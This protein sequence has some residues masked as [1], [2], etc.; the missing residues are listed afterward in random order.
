MTAFATTVAFLISLTTAKALDDRASGR[1]V[2][3]KVQLTAPAVAN[4]P[5]DNFDSSVPG[6][7]SRVI[8]P[9]P[10]QTLKASCQVRSRAQVMRVT[11]ETTVIKPAPATLLPS[12]TVRPVVVGPRPVTT[13]PFQQSGFPAG[14]LPL[15]SSNPSVSQPALGATN[16]ELAS[17]RVSR[18]SSVDPGS[19]SSSEAKMTLGQISSGH[20]AQGSTTDLQEWDGCDANSQIQGGYG[21]GKG[22]GGGDAGGAD[23]GKGGCGKAMIN[24]QF[25]AHM[26]KYFLKCV[27]QGAKDAGINGVQKV[28][29]NHMGVYVDRTTKAGSVSQHAYGRA[30]DIG[31]ID[32]L[33]SGGNNLGKIDT[34]VGAYSGQNQQ[35][36][37]GFLKCWQESMKEGQ[38]CGGEG[39]AGGLGHEKSNHPLKNADHNDHIHM[40]FAQCKGNPYPVGGSK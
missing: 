33:G 23:Q 17:G 26:K 34:N 14:S 18:P 15:A 35:M 30:M 28:F 37:D 32:L 39:E 21:G 5:C 20:S 16:S 38:M 3:R 2:Q 9:S 8:S 11:P 22:D 36:Y 6:P 1:P 25:A 19:Q 29:I 12:T 7:S 31:T 24:P 40:S 4:D 10:T 27:Q 13:V